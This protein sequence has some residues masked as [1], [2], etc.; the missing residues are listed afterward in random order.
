MYVTVLK[1]NEHKSCEEVRQN[2]LT[3]CFQPENCVRTKMVMWLQI[4]I[5][6]ISQHKQKHMVLGLGLLN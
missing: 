2:T 4:Q 5:V 6:D 3:K 1:G